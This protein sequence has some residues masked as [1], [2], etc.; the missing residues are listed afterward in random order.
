M[1]WFACDLGRR[2]FI[3]LFLNVFLTFKV[4]FRKFII[5]LSVLFGI[6]SGDNYI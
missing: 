6:Y 1:N 2:L 3:F 5:D 4:T